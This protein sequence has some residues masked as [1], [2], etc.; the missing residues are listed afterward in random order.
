M[1]RPTKL[2]DGKTPTSG[3]ASFG[4]GDPSQ[5]DATDGETSRSDQTDELPE[6]VCSETSKSR[7][8]KEAVENEVK[9]PD[10][11]PSAK[12]EPIDILLDRT[13]LSQHQR[14]LKQPGGS[15]ADMLVAADIE[16]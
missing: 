7:G 16:G 8:G 9:D 11:E 2:E 13:K 5:Q 6:I 15:D 4:E 10:H 1:R 3:E 14:L 12:P